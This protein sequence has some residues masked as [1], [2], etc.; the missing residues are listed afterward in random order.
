MSD[1]VVVISFKHYLTAFAVL[2]AT[3]H[4]AV[5]KKINKNCFCAFILLELLH[6]KWY[7]PCSKLYI[8]VCA[9]L[10]QRLLASR[11]WCRGYCVHLFDMVVCV[12]IHASYSGESIWSTCQFMYLMLCHH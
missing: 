8:V 11:T 5:S 12:S 2:T 9:L 10:F 1:V 7:S 6:Y 4:E 3:A